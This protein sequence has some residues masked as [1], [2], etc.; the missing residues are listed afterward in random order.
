MSSVSTTSPNW[1]RSKWVR[2]VQPPL[3]GLEV[4]EFG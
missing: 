1:F 3:T 2:L 4:D